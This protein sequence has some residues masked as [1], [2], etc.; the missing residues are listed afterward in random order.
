MALSRSLAPSEGVVRGEGS[1]P[2]TRRGSGRGSP[3]GRISDGGSRLATVVGLPPGSARAT[4]G[5]GWG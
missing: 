4:R 2:P 3:A 1:R 5:P